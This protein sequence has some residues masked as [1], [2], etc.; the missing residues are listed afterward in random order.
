VVD[1]GR[2]GIAA[3]VSAASWQRPHVNYGRGGDDARERVRFSGEHVND[4][5]CSPVCRLTQDLHLHIQE[6]GADGE[7]VNTTVGDLCGRPAATLVHNCCRRCRRRRAQLLCARSPLVPQITIPTS[8]HGDY[9]P[10]AFGQTRSHPRANPPE[11]GV[12]RVCAAKFAS[13]G[14]KQ[15]H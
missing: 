9:S 7:W 15:L 3:L 2:D 4:Q 13:L 11:S 5:Q 1:G 10:A 14:L 6:A 8:R 12:C